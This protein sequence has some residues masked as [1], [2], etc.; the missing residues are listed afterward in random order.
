ML[1]VLL[2]VPGCAGME[3]QAQLFESLRKHFK[4]HDTVRPADQKSVDHETEKARISR[5]MQPRYD[6]DLVVRTRA[7]FERKS[8]ITR[9]GKLG[10]GTVLVFQAEIV[11]R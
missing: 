9:D 3:Y 10:T 2:I 4:R 5:S 1:A 8:G 7:T 6:T 11:S